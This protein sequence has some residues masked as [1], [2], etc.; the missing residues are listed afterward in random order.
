MRKIFTLFLS[1]MLVSTLSA[2]KP[3]AVIK[4]AS[5]A[6]VIGGEIDEVW[7]EAD[8][9][10]IAVVFRTETPTIGGLGETWWKAL[11]TDDG[12]YV[13]VNVTDNDW[14]PWKE[15]NGTNGWQYDK[16]ELYFDANV[17]NLED[18]KGGQNP[19]NA[20]NYQ[21]APDPIL[22]NVGGE[23]SEDFLVGT[24]FQYAYMVNDPNYTVEYFVPF[25]YLN[26]AAGVPVDISG[27]IGF[28]ITVIDN[29]APGDDN[30]RQRTDWSNAGVKDENWNNMDDA[31]IITLEG[32]AVIYIDAITISV[33][34]DITENGQTLQI[35]SVIEP[36]D[37]TIK[38]LKWKIQPESTAKATISSDGVITP[39]TN[40]ALVVM[41]S[42]SDD[43]IESNVLTISISG[44]IPSIQSL[45]IVKNGYFDQ[46]DSD[47]S[48][49]SWGGWVDTGYGD[50]SIAGGQVVDGVVMLNSILAHASE[51]WHYQFNQNQ[52]TGLADIPYVISFVAWADN[53]RNICFDFEDTSGNG[54]NRYGVSSDPDSNGRSEWTFP[55]TMEPVRYTFHTTFDQMVPT[56]D[57]KIQ[58]MIS[59]ATGMVYLDSITV[60]SESDL[61]LIPTAVK[62]IGLETFEVYPNPAQNEL[63]INLS[64]PNLAVVIYNSVGIKMEET[65]VNGT[66]HIFDVRNYTPGLYFVKANNTVMKFVK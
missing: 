60:V 52:L 21:I 18:G 41:A 42:S 32:A 25:S 20:G 56:T 63:H 34:G 22:T 43:F 29:D 46:V 19:G 39:I 64:T 10:D 8:Q 57:Q 35:N 2:Q 23:L 66:H 12:I 51:N 28:D 9:N 1:V 47:G 36:E 59:Q 17:F 7:G 6:P 53:D 13:L 65:V 3:E 30:G 11:W 62:Q 31:G 26:D 54:Y 15:A 16:I 27:T 40:G 44:Q 5:V 58:F 33:D 49:T 37:A 55:V 45:S 38:I 24:G 50:P 4:K 48:A 14:Y 61:A